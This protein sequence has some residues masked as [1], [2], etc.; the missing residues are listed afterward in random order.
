M[1][2]ASLKGFRKKAIAPERSA[3]SLTP[4][5]SWAVMKITGTMLPRLERRSWTSRPFSPGI[6]TS[7]TKQS[8]L[9]E[10]IASRRSRKSCPDLN[11]SA[12]METDRTNRLTARQTDSSSSTIAMSGLELINDVGLQKAEKKQMMIGRQGVTLSGIYRRERDAYIGLW[13]NTRNGRPKNVQLQIFR[14]VGRMSI[15]ANWLCRYRRVRRL[16]RARREIV[17]PFFPSLERGA[18]SRS[19][20]LSQVRRRFACSTSL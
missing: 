11:V 7:R 6:C 4:T 2:S 18:P 9:N 10:G 8:G 19:F 1:S 16:V 15:P 13:S 3:F 17:L 5:S 20:R 12:S 14:E